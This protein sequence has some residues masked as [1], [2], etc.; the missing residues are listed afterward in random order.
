MKNLVLFLFLSMIAPQFYGV[1]LDQAKEIFNQAN[2][3]YQNEDYES[4][5]N[6]YLQLEDDYA[7]FEYYYNLGNTY[8]KLNDIPSSILYYEKGHKIDPNNDDLETNLMIVNQ[9]VVDKIDAIPLSE[10]GGFWDNVIS[11]SNLNKWTSVSLVFLF[12]AFLMF[13]YY[14][15]K[16]KRK[17]IIGLG[18]LFLMV[19][20][21]GFVL[22]QLTINRMKTN[23]E[24][25]IFA[26][27]LEVVNQ[28]N[29]T[30]VEFVIHEGTK[31]Q[32]NSFID[33]WTEIQLANG[34][35]GW[36]LKTSYK[37]I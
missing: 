3:A 20:I 17:L 10:I 11:E 5:K 13:G 8:Y 21:F 18:S 4:A 7:S 26:K 34:N 37:E 30:Q 24:A 32:I 6:F 19:A 22:G 28:P 27:E 14:L 23:S 36:V 25:I 15:L 12:L 29:G 33:D 1:D 9:S 31:V 2:E 35:V 16:N